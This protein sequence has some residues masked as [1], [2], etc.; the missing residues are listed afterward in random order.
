RVQQRHASHDNRVAIPLARDPAHPRGRHPG[1]AG[2][3][4][5]RRPPRRERATP[6]RVTREARTS[7]EYRIEGDVVGIPHTEI[8]RSRRGQGRGAKLVRYALDDVR[9]TNRRVN[10]QCWFVAE[11]MTEHPEYANLAS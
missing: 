8:E 10:P 6:G 11:F 5:P 2:P 1:H 4:A 9:A 7:A 3:G